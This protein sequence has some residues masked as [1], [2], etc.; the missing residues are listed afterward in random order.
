MRASKR[1]THGGLFGVLK[2][3]EAE[4]LLR[5]NRAASTRLVPGVLPGDGNAL[6]QHHLQVLAST[7]ALLLTHPDAQSRSLWLRSQYAAALAEFAQVERQAGRLEAD[8]SKWLLAVSNGLDDFMTA[9]G[10]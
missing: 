1:I 9:E 5:V 3:P 7:A 8:S 2:R 10:W 4:R 6:W